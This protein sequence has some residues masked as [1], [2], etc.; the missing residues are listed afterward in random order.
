MTAAGGEETSRAGRARAFALFRHSLIGEAAH[1]VLSTRQRG[2]LVR[3]LAGRAHPGPFAQPVVVSRATIDRWT[4]WA[5]GF[6]GPAG[7]AIPHVI[8]RHAHHKC[9]CLAAR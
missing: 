7:Q 2:R 5:G 8:G 9:R 1:A 4:W 6:D 3:E